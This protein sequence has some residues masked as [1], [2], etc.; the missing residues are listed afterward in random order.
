MNGNILKKLWK[1]STTKMD[2]ISSKKL[3]YKFK[4]LKTIYD[5]FKKF[6]KR[7]FTKNE[8]SKIQKKPINKI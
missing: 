8:L 1:N 2:E 7:K 4:F 3:K 6:N 5:N